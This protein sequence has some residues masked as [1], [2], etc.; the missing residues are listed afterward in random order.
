[1]SPVGDDAPPQR[2]D[3]VTGMPRPP[4]WP[5]RQWL[6]LLGLFALAVVATV[7]SFAIVSRI[8]RPALLPGGSAAPVIR[9]SDSA[10]AHHDVLADSRGG[11]VVLEFFE[12]TCAVCQREVKPL[13]DLHARHPSLA[14]YSLDA[15]R[16]SA[17]SVDGFRRSQAGGCISWPLLLDPSSDVLRSYRVT[18]VPTVYLLDG[19]G[20]VVYTGTGE[21][22]VA[23]LDQALAG[24]GAHG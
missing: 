14:V 6:R 13:C 24:L 16:E 8:S 7:V 20:R 1:M 2:R 17:T 15:A 19:R 3:P 11:P 21:A 18:V 5:R 22:G 23:G 9:L 10:G 4:L 12:T